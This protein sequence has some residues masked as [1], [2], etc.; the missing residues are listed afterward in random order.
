MSFEV[1]IPNISDSTHV[2]STLV[3]A[4]T[5]GASFRVRNSDGDL[6]FVRNSD[7]P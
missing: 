7:C 3:I 2:Q 5:L 1:L 4:G 6:D